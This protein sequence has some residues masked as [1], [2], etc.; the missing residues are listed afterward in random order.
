[1]VNIWNNK[2][3]DSAE[4][5]VNIKIS[6]TTTGVWLL[7]YRAILVWVICKVESNYLTHVEPWDTDS[8]KYKFFIHINLWV[9]ITE[10]F[11]GEQV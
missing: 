10:K 4:K 1:M 7:S 11:G 9:I 6:Q 8:Q 5:S 3:M 2:C